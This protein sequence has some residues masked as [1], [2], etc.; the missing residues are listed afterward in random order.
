MGDRGPD[1][2]V[3]EP[4]DPE[5]ERVWREHWAPLVAP[6][7]TVDMDAVKRELYGYG[8]LLDGVPKVYMHI[9]DGR[10]SKPNTDPDAVISVAD[11]REQERWEEYEKEAR[12]DER[13]KCEAE[14]RESLLARAVAFSERT[15]ALAK[16]QTAL[17]EAAKGAH[18]AW[19]EWTIDSGALHL[20]ECMEKLWKA[21]GK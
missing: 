14:M 5:V 2:V 21:V 16:E 3:P 19:Q 7:G 10:I 6:A 9:T 13:A 17:R 15:E 20:D 8:V 12:A 4:L 1:V 18:R 11:E